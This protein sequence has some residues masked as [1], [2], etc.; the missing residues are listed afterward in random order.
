MFLP[1]LDKIDTISTDTFAYSLKVGNLQSNLAEQAKA[2]QK[3]FAKYEKFFTH[4]LQ[5]KEGFAELFNLLPG[6]LHINGCI[7][8]ANR[9]QGI[10]LCSSLKDIFL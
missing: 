9:V 10:Q 8:D 7:V 1:L 4:A 6:K 3:S 5:G 2:T